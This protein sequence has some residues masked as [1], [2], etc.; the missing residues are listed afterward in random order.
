MTMSNRGH[1]NCGADNQNW[2]GGITINNGYIYV[3]LPEH[4]MA[5]LAGHKYVQLAILIW[6]GANG[7][8]FPEGMEPHHKNGIKMDNTPLNIEPLPHDV[9]SIL[10]PRD[11]SGRFKKE[12]T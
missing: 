1:Y 3:L 4:P 7:R 8:P 6:E 11:S 9:H 2:R 5:S 10:R 12:E